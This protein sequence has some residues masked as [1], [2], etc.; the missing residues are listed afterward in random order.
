MKFRDRMVKCSIKSLLCLSVLFCAG[1]SYAAEYYVDPGGS[2]GNPGTDALPWA[3]IAYGT[4]QIQPGDVLHIRPGTYRDSARINIRDNN[5][6]LLG[7]GTVAVDPCFSEFQTVNN[8]AWT[9]YDAGR[10]IYRTTNTYSPTA[11]TENVWGTF[12]YDGG[13][14][15]LVTYPTYAKLSSDYQ[16][17]GQ[18][19]GPGMFWDKNGDQR[20]YIRLAKTE[21]MN[22]LGYGSLPDDPNQL[23]M[24]I[25]NAGAFIYIHAGYSGV[26]VSGITL[27][28]GTMRFGT[29]SYD[30]TVSNLKLDGTATRYGIRVLDTSHSMTFD[31]LEIND[32]FPAWLTWEDVKSV[33]DTTMMDYG[34]YIHRDT[35]DITIKNSIFKNLHDAIDILYTGYNYSIYNNEFSDIQDDS[36]QLGSATY[37][38][39][40]HHNRMIRVGTG[41]SRQSVTDASGNPVD[42]PQPGRKYIHH[43]IIDASQEKLFYRKRAD[44]T[45]SSPN[46]DADGYY[47]LRA[48][49]AHSPDKI[50]TDGDPRYI[51]NNTILIGDTVGGLG[52][53][54]Y[55]QP[56]R[57]TDPYQ[58]VINN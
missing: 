36:V 20:I 32:Y 44:G 39:D 48:F 1:I 47:C 50:G 28:Q 21:Q 45:Y 53:D 46:A 42:N 52:V 43:N 15:K 6:S 24:H 13:R 27:K 9:L 38:V 56:Y 41:V 40:I 31:G 2:N 58:K 29:G 16:Y 34:L 5:V 51:Y 12:E 25:T 14:Y 4:G 23:V 35:H 7:E 18:Y 8:G 49:T 54:L 30:C 22:L 55:G 57:S 26:T 11:E 37:E 19:A 33:Y 3:T 10:N 17:L